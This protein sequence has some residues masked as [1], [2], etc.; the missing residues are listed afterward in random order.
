MNWAI[1]DF[2]EKT[3]WNGSNIWMLLA[4]F[5]F[6]VLQ[7]HLL[8]RYD[9]RTTW[10]LRAS[11]IPIVTL[12]SLRSGF[13]Y[14]YTANGQPQLQG[15]GQQVNLTVGCAVFCTIVCSIGWGLTLR[16]P[17]LKVAH[18]EANGGEKDVDGDSMH[19]INRAASSLP[20]CF[21]GSILP[22]E[23]DLLFNI[24]GIG[25]ERGVKD[26]APA[27]PVPTFTRQ[28][29]WA[30]II[31]QLATIPFYLVLYDAVLALMSDP[32]INVNLNARHGGSIWDS[33]MGSFGFAGPYL[34]GGLFALSFVAAQNLAHVLNA[35]LHVALLNDLPSRWEPPPARAPWVSTSV[36][37]FWSKRWHQYLRI[38]FMTLGYWPVRAALRPIVGKRFA[39]MAA[40]CGTFLVSGLIHDLGRVTMAPEPGFAITQVTLF[41]VLQPVADFGE[42]LWEQYTGRR[43][44]GFWG[45]L[46]T[47]TWLLSF[48]PLLFEVSDALK[49]SRMY[50]E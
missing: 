19:R 25:W 7:I 26:G 17:R 9:P 31:K 3:P 27:L 36:R 23:L 22:L 42:Q 43:G 34:L 8:L 40:V 20:V 14:Y 37:E 10:A 21:P 1:P 5:P 47:M 46:W 39:S 48:S 44:R 33:R 6:M 11:L 4:P 2:Y 24:R 13:A 41:F 18:V 49:R 15:R 45:W 16:R 32:R 12:L 30:W 35:T 29:R 38:T 50:H 28:E